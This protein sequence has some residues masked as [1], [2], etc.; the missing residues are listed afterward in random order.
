VPHAQDPPP[1][2]LTAWRREVGDR[3]RQQRRDAGLTQEQ[4][5]GLIYVER[6]TIHRIEAGTVSPPLD[7]ILQIAY[8]LGIEPAALLPGGPEE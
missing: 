7:R 4:L 2:W 8:A 1:D 6:R 5:A 3:I